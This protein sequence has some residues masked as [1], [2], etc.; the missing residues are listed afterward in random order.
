MA[1]GSIGRVV[2]VITGVAAIAFIAGLVVA[3]V[4]GISPTVSTQNSNENI[5]NTSPI[6]WLA[7]GNPGLK[8]V[9][10]PIPSAASAT[11]G[12]PS[13]VSNGTSL[14]LGSVTAGA[15]AESFTLTFTSAPASTEVVWQLWFNGS[16]VTT[17]TVYLETPASAFSGSVTF[18]Y[19]L[20]PAGGTFVLNQVTSVA[21]QCTT[22]GNCP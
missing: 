8:L 6:S 2:Y 10:S 5:V 9:P 12:T 20:A 17:I 18:F 1:S 3:A 22:V 16:G 14:A 15:E 4:S 7:L 11:V 13:V 19:Q 21:Q